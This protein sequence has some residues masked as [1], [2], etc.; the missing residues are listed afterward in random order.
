M[1]KPF[2]HEG[3]RQGSSRRSVVRLSQET[4]KSPKSSPYSASTRV[5]SRPR[6]TAEPALISHTPAVPARRIARCV[7][8]GEKAMAVR[9]TR[10]HRRTP[11]KWKRIEVAS[12]SGIELYDDIAEEFMLR[13]LGFEPDEYLIT[14]ESSLRDFV[15]VDDPELAAIH[16]KIRGVYAVD[17]SDLESGNLLEIFERLRQPR[18]EP[19]TPPVVH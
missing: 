1:T 3:A 5:V 2:C 14:D 15:G 7:T 6:L 16:R 19:R 18:A 11:F 17:V 12:T 9:K 8:L 10:V 13:I 4:P